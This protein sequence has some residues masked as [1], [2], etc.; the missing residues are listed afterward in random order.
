VDHRRPHRAPGLGIEADPA[1]DDRDLERAL[2]EA[3]GQ[4]PRLLGE[5]TEG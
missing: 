1:I 4:R 2:A 5:A 3:L